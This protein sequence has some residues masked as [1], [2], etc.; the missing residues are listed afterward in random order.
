MERQHSD[1]STPLTVE[2]M[3]AQANTPQEALAI[4][5][6]FKGK[7][8]LE[9]PSQEQIAIY[10]AM[11]A[12]MLR[13]GDITTAFRFTD[14]AERTQIALQ[15]SQTVNKHERVAH[16]FGETIVHFQA[17]SESLR[18][19]LYTHGEAEEA[20]LQKRAEL[21]N[22]EEG[23]VSSQRNIAAEQQADN[24]NTRR[25]QEN[26]ANKVQAAGSGMQEAAYRV[27]EASRTIMGAATKIEQASYR[28]GH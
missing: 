28:Q 19:G 11:A 6:S 1:E 4:Y 15:E 5:K 14:Y 23:I 16:Y 17:T 7:L 18:Q 25:A 12:T 9:S 27:E 8:H 26:T 10:E 2:Q 3:F 20:L 22:W 24:A 13:L 21:L